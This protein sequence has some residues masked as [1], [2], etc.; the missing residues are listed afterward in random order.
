MINQKNILF[1]KNDCMM[2]NHLIT[3]LKN[4]KLLDNFKL[5]CIDNIDPKMLPKQLRCV[6]TVVLINNGK[7]LEKNEIFGWLNSIKFITNPL[8]SE[9][10][11]N[12]D[13]SEDNKEKKNMKGYNKHEMGEISDK[14]AYVEKESAFKHTYVGIDDLKQNAI[15]TEPEKNK[16]TANDS[17]T[18]LRQLENERKNK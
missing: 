11:N 3:I 4:D 18:L 8:H 5:Q 13:D 7:I 1:Y 14:F 12:K 17:R 10:R 2:S 15:F 9:K 6:P 16:L